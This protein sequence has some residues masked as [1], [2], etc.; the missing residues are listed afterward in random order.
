MQLSTYP[1]TSTKKSVTK[2]G[3]REGKIPAILYA[4]G[5]PNLLLGIAREEMEAVLRKI[6]QGR[7]GTTL[8]DLTVEGKSLRAIIK[9]VQYEPTTY[10]MS[11]IDFSE[12]L[13]HVLMRVNVPIQCTGVD[14]CVGVRSEGG[15]FRQVRH[16]L[17]IECLPEHLPSHFSMDVTDL[18]LQ[19]S[20]R[21][22]DITIAPNLTLLTASRDV[23]ANVSKRA[24]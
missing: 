2:Q 22:S 5:K 17:Y 19:Q 24:S 20:K 15:S 21:V 7:L 6:P 1:R 10:R 3:R 9:D 14:M 8:F 11:H 13:P 12:I 18:K 23:V 4:A 16:S